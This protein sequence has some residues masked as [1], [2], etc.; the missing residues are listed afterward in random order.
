MSREGISVAVKKRRNHEI[1]EK[2]RRKIARFKK[3][4]NRERKTR[5]NHKEATATFHSSAQDRSTAV[6]TP[7]CVGTWSLTLARTW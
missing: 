2:V 7:P 1:C 3:M 6:A 4:S 5:D